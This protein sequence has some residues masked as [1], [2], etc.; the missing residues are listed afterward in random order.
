MLA[1][2]RKQNPFRV[3]PVGQR[4]PISTPADAR[5]AQLEKKLTAAEARY[6]DLHGRYA[7]LF[8]L[9][10]MQAQRIEYLQG[11]LA[12]VTGEPG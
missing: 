11:E 10:Q 7:T 3:E 1:W 9:N 6:N 5:I 2:F 8:E 12:G 4:V